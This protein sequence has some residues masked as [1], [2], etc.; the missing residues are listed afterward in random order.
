MSPASSTAS[1]VPPFEKGGQG[2]FAFAFAPTKVKSKS[3][4]IPLFQRGKRLAWIVACC[5][6]L[7]A[8]CNRE[9][10]RKVV[11]IG[12]AKSE[13]G[14][15]LHDYPNGIRALEAIL[16]SSPD[17]RGKLE[18]A[19]YPEGWPADLKALDGAATIVWYFDGLDKHPLRDA[20]RRAAFEAA[21][22]RGAGLVALHQASTV[23]PDDALGLP[24]WLGAARYG[25]FDRTTQWAELV[26]AT[27]SQPLVRGIDA[28]AYRDEFYPTFRPAAGGGKFVPILKAALNPQYRDG[29]YLVEDRAEAANVAW[30]FERDGG[31][32]SFVYSGAHYLRT[33]DQPDARKM[34]L[35]AIFWT[36]G[37]DVPENGVRSA[38]PNEAAALLGDK[39]STAER[40]ATRSA[41]PRRATFHIDSGRSGW[42]S[43]ETALT[44]EKV[45]GDAF[46]LVWESPQLDA[47]DG[48]APRLYASPLYVDRIA[49]TKG[50]HRGAEFAVVFAASSNGYVYAINARRSG[51]VAPGRI[52][53]RT[54]L[55]APCHLQPAPLD[56]VPT[57]ILS[58]PIVDIAQGRL[59]VAHCDPQKRWQAY[60]L[61]IASGDV[62]PGWPVR[63]DEE[64]FNAVNANA[65]PQ[66]V[67]PK[68]RFDFRVQRGALNLSPDGSQLY[69]VFG[70]T[71]TGWI[72]AVDTRRARVSSAFA[73]VAMPHR[74]SGGIWGAGGPAVDAQGSVYV[75]T[76]SGFD[77]YQDSLH[78]WTQ[79]VLKLSQPGPK[80]FV[81]QGTYTPFN[82][83]RTA[84]MDIDLGAGGAL[85]LPDA[86][87]DAA[88]RLMAVGG[89]QGNVYL[90]DRDKLPGRLDRR[91]PCGDD[92]SQDG[93]LLA[94]Q[95]QPQFGTRGPLNVFGPY[96][97]QDAA[98][99]LARARSV[100][101][102]FR[103]AA[104]EDF[105]FVT[106]NAKRAQGS[107]VSVPP[108]LARIAVVRKN[109]GAPY[110]R[111]DKIQKTLILGNPGSP[112]V[113]S[114]GP[115]NAIVWIL[116]ENASRSALLS[117]A[118]APRPVL[119]ALDASTL[120][121]LWRSA[122]GEL[123]TSGK[124][125]EPAFGGGLVFVGT[126]RIQAFGLGG[127]KFAGRAE[128]A[129][130]AK[131]QADPALAGLDGEAIYGQRCAICHDHPQGN[132]PP[133]SLIASRSRERIVE[134][135]S[136]GAMRAQA[137][138]LSAEQ[139]EDVARYLKK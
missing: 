4:F 120:D 116:D 69:V 27:A 132:I 100:P 29:H 137:Q 103:D 99:D 131:R 76:G 94:P 47:A 107:S 101:A 40:E 72:A 32:R 122:P 44:P 8:A 54:R 18:V 20:A 78:D 46:G 112:V 42:R 52:L 85:L 43:N 31:G 7:L 136:Q 138:G 14:A 121:I 61:D 91:P 58:T 88:P 123:F 35:N 93:S 79:S 56:G 16:E 19:A 6:V 51:D 57:G 111:V 97:D 49:M 15:G 133:R 90:L 21:M 109:G 130:A 36:A 86:K 5:I 66:R 12:G 75:V 24:R 53:W 17:A 65:G 10:P 63:L 70:E 113:T 104:G 83:C 134:A 96:S 25:M 77:G 119:Y 50:Q 73:A 30:A 106:G 11:L 102:A 128:T 45:A 126:D 127:R 9:P 55:A 118:D 3:P 33:L 89:K 95:P 87:A 71:E 74:G 34:L 37:L 125:N 135:L 13:K 22:R 110:L 117:G 98:L 82:Y 26:P 81:L 60:A 62:L 92:A 68:R 114:D 84:K 80:S 23:P 64:T 59:Y 105:L 124:Y 115:R 139:I 39:G 48:Q 67:P 108:S 38:A 1:A 41:E 2:G 129:P 28:F